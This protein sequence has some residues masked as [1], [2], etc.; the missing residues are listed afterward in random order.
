M[1]LSTWNFEYAL[2]FKSIETIYLHYVRHHMSFIHDF[3]LSKIHFQQSGPLK[4]I[5]FSRFV[6]FISSMESLS[7]G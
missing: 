4:L 3:G 1:I 2:Q 5:I 6:R 7:K